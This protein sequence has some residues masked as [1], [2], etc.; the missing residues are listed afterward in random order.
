MLNLICKILFKAESMSGS[1]LWQV[2]KVDERVAID[3]PDQQVA[4]TG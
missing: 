3:P 1:A 4:S 2:F